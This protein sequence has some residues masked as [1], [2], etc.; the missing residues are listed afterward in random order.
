[1]LKLKEKAFLFVV[2]RV[3]SNSWLNMAED[4]AILS[5]IKIP[6]IPFPIDHFKIVQPKCFTAESQQA[7]SANV[8]KLLKLSREPVGIC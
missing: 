4:T 6:N 7:A 8:V 2:A 1:M 5:K 3:F